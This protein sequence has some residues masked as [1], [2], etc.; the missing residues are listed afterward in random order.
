MSETQQDEPAAPP[1]SRKAQIAAAVQTALIGALAGAFVTWISA[2]WLGLFARQPLH[3][4]L[5][6]SLAVGGAL[7]VLALIPVLRDLIQRHPDKVRTALCVLAGA[8][9]ATGV[10][11]VIRTAAA[12]D[13]CPAPAE[14][15][16]VTASE[17]VAELT[18]RTRAYV[19]EHQTED[20][21]PVVRMTVGVAPP[22]I[23]LR[24][25]F[26]NGWEWREDRGEQPYA[27]L[28]DLQPDAWVASSSAEA[29][30]LRAG[31]L[32]SLSARKRE[33]TVGRDQ[34]VLAMS[35]KRSDELD[36]YMDNPDD[37]PF[38]EV[39]DTLTNT[40]GMTI[41]RPFPETSVAALIGT[42]DVFHD[43]GL[44][45]SR[46]LEAERKLVD[47][48]L[49]A[50]TVTSLL[51]EFDRLADR[52]DGGDP[53]IALLVPG[54]SV[55][56]YN[57][58]R[59]EG[60]EGT[61]D[62]ASLVA[63]RHHD[64]STLDYQFVKVS[65][66]DQ[67]SPQ[68]EKLVEHFGAWLRDH[69]LFPNAPGPRDSELGLRELRQLRK[70][71]LDELR[72]KLG[73][74][75]LVD[76]SG[77]ADRP[78]RVQAAEAVR[79][80]SRLLQPRDRVEVFGLH[81]RKKNGP[82]EVT[83]IAAGSTKE[84]LGDVATL[85]ENTAFDDWDAPASAGLSLLGAGD[86]TVAAPVVLLT[87]GRLFDNEGRG[88]AAQVIARALEDASTVSGLYVVVFGQDECAVTALPGTGKPYRCVTVGEGADQALTRAIITVRGWR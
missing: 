17:N 58:G 46:Y 59:V 36:T 32:R 37:Y 81:A 63:V 20:G 67:R 8:A 13:Q 1:P 78:V 4:Q 12:D 76:T 72:P 19:R 27:R 55:D 31:Q 86:E 42:H 84:Q 49:G 44:P 16:L 38:G 70:L 30:E 24:D 7:G 11:T 47:D 73:L 62:S 9:V 40:M 52:T 83:S 66:P 3:V 85:I 18:A 69:P 48:G 6:V 25:A 33:D 88:D 41:A 45:E 23:H 79:A 50:D 74:R 39:W 29:D 80:N 56:D 51:C 28:Y 87:D 64:L 34:L 54:H 2:P 61:G 75:L 68:R 21:C 5:W 57:A 43:R 35:G 65:W 15:R 82:A 77:S 60:C 10:W 26:D 22:P 71:V 14:L 53:K